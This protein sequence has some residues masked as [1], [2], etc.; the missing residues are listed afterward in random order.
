VRPFSRALLLPVCLA[1]GACG[2]PRLITPYRMEIQQGNYIS[3]EMVAQLKP[4]MTREQ[5]RYILGTPLVT[6]IF[7]GERWDYVY[8]RDRQGRPYEERKIS[9]IFEN[10]KLA[11]IEGDVVPAAPKKKS[12][13]PE[14][15]GGAHA[16]AQGRRP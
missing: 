15:E 11:R 2:A 14:R 3:Q 4:G 10:G 1:L 9:V 12:A 6:D 13:A 16:E 7:H 8:T 5:V